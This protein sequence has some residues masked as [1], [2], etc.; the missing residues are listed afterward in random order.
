MFVYKNQVKKINEFK[1][2]KD[3]TDPE[4]KLFN[5][6]YREFFKEQLIIKFRYFFL[7]FQFIFVDILCLFFIK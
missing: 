7:I 2:G 6:L 3:E 5:S 4:R 1:P